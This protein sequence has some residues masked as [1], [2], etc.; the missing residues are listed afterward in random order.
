MLNAQLLTIDDLL[1]ECPDLR[2][3]YLAPRI[4]GAQDAGEQWMVF[5]TECRNRTLDCL[6]CQEMLDQIV[7]EFSV[8]VHHTLDVAK[9]S[10]GIRVAC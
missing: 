10:D 2:W 3:Y 1:E 7:F 9:P 4:I 5:Q 8:L 6:Y